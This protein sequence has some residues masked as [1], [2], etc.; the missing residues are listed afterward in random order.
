MDTTVINNANGRPDVWI[1][2]AELPF[3]DLTPVYEEIRSLRHAL[4]GSFLP[5]KDDSIGFYYSGFRFRAVKCGDHIQIL[6]NDPNCPPDILLVPL[7][8]L[9]PPQSPC[10]LKQ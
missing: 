1:V 10:S 2:L 3:N 9:I 6:V 7:A 8:K 5:A 4:Y